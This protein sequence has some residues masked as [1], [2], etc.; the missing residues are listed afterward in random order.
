MSKFA[1]LFE[2]DGHQV[3]VTLGEDGPSVVIKFRD[4][5]DDLYVMPEISFISKEKGDEAL[6][7]AWK[8][9]DKAFAEFDANTAFDFRTKMLEELNL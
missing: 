4:S 8:L 9:A 2:R 6:L 5:N 1:K 7:S 3:L